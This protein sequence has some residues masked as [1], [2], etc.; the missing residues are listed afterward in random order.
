MLGCLGGV[1]TV[2]TLK[3]GLHSET[4]RNHNGNAGCVDCADLPRL[5][6][7]ARRR[8]RQLRI[9]IHT[10]HS[11]HFSNRFKK[12]GSVAPKMVAAQSALTGFVGGQ[13]DL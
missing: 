3:K 9:C 10:L 5:S 6:L 12:L 4:R 2:Q 1:Y 8:V 11:L 7:C 13:C